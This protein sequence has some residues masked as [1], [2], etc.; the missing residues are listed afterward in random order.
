MART[1]QRL[2]NRLSTVFSEYAPRA[3][4]ASEAAEQRLR[5]IEERDRARQERERARAER[6]RNPQ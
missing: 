5:E 4:R 6:L 2:S 1:G 3:H